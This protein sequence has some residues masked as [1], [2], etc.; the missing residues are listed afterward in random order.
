MNMSNQTRVVALTM[1]FEYIPFVPDEF[2][3]VK[4]LWFDIGGC[5]SSSFPAE[6]GNAFQYSSPSWKPSFTGD[7]L[8]ALSHLHDGGTHLE[9]RKNTSIVCDAEAIYRTY[10]SLQSSNLGEEHISTISECANLGRSEAGD[11]WSITAYYDASK[12]S[13]MNRMDGSPEP[14]MG[15]SLAYMT[16]TPEERQLNMSCRGHRHKSRRLN[17]ILG[18]GII[19]GILTIVAIR[20]KLNKGSR[21]TVSLRQHFYQPVNFLP[22]AAKE[23]HDE[24]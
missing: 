1:T 18:G 21:R 13:L 5:G 9:L 14:V 22:V 12:H 20:V 8:F 11:E 2:D 4:S 7:V 17:W 3:T 24:D 16:E 23:Y 6:P 15:I 10:E 19:A